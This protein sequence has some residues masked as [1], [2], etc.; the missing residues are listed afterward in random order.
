MS[1]PQIEKKSPKK[2]RQRSSNVN[3]HPKRLAP[4]PTSKSR[5]Q[6]RKV[7]TL[8]HRYS[9]LKE[10]TE[11]LDKRREIDSLIEQIGGRKA[12]QRASQIST[13][14]HSTSKWVLGCLAQNGWLYGIFDGDENDV[15]SRGK[16][17]NGRR[18]TRLLEIGAI[19]TELIDAAAPLDPVAKGVT[20]N[21]FDCNSN[22]GGLNSKK[23]HCLYVRAI[24]LH[25]MHDSIE[26]V[27]FLSLP[28]RN[29]IEEKYDVI[30]CSMVLN[31]VPTPLKRGEMILRIVH[32]L[33]PGG[34][35][36]ITLP[37]TC[38]N[39]SPYLDYE[40]F[41]KLLCHTGLQLVDCPKDSPKLAFFIGRKF[42]SS[43]PRMFNPKWTKVCEI[44]QGRKYRNDFSI[45][46]PEDDIL[47]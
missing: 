39:L 11:S 23:N 21:V 29:D 42:V 5:K 16:R 17:R 31:C 19:N 14:Y 38:L 18:P 20:G 26:Q 47:T 41:T 22:Q 46:L 44:R 7:T 4:L 1:T 6:A 8:F 27:D 40:M 34:L 37:K 28:M 25:A 10:R 24:D 3:I 32:F 12:Y 45:L 30:V 43:I 2:R 33:R 9:H 36:Y 15:A 13:S 35:V